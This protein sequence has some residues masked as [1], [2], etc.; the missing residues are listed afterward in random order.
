MKPLLIALAGLALGYIVGRFDGRRKAF[1]DAN[2]A[3]RYL[4]AIIR[5][6]VKA[7]P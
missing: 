5:E 6:E 3:M 4:A 2:A 7:P 1:A